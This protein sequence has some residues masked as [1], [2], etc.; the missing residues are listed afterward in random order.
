MEVRAWGSREEGRG[1]PMPGLVTWCKESLK[2]AQRATPGQNVLRNVAE[3]QTKHSSRVDLRET[4][5]PGKL[6]DGGGT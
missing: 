6:P 3:A 4:D 2:C 1:L 5:I